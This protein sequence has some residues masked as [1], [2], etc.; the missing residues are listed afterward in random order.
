MRGRRP[1]E[2]HRIRQEKEV[3]PWSRAAPR[4]SEVDTLRDAT[5]QDS[6]GGIRKETLMR[7]DCE[8]GIFNRYVP[9]A[10]QARSSTFL[11]RKGKFHEARNLFAVL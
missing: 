4:C 6:E 1:L 2:S 11:P 3:V 9:A 8:A 5:R 7:R 10:G